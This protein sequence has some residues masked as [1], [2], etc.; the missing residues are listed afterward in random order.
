MMH[1][2]YLLICIQFDRLCGLVVRVS[3]CRYRGPGFDPRRY[4]I[5]WVVVGLE[6]GPLSLVRSSEELLE[7]K[8]SGSKSRKQR[9]TTVGTR[10][11]DHVT[12]LY[13][14][15]LAVTSPTGGGRS[16]GIVRVLTKATE[17]YTY[18]IVHYS[19]FHDHSKHCRILQ[20]HNLR[21]DVIYS[22]KS[23]CLL[24]IFFS[25]YIQHLLRNVNQVTQIQLIF[26]TYTSFFFLDK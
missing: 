12:P 21:G 14:Q 13:P 1:N 22:H 20:V 7:W 6:W 9:L 16:V 19:S 4:Q 24:K 11:A 5:F 10:C 2:F 23:T 25:N 3:G 15:K 8:S 17:F 18:V 26:A